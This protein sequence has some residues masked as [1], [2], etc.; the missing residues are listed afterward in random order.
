MFECERVEY[1]R[2]TYAYGSILNNDK[3]KD[4]A[5]NIGGLTVLTPSLNIVHAQLL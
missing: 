4:S 1:P 5:S 3:R 2:G